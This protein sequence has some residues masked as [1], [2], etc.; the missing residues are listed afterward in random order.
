MSKDDKDATNCMYC[1]AKTMTI[2]DD[3]GKCVYELCGRFKTRKIDI[4]L[5]E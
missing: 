5:G 4:R 2:T 3:N 1:N